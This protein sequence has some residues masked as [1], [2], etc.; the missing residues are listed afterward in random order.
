MVKLDRFT[1]IDPSFQGIGSVD[2]TFEF[3]PCITP[4][5]L[6]HQSKRNLSMILEDTNSVRTSPHASVGGSV[7]FP[8]PPMLPPPITSTTPLG[9]SFIPLMSLLI[10]YAHIPFYFRFSFTFPTLPIHPYAPPL[11]CDRTRSR[12]LSHN[13]RTRSLRPISLI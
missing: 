10:R 2:Y 3:G 8:F 4:Q 6:W 13:N 9:V 7:A 1:S 11:Q 12:S 5:T